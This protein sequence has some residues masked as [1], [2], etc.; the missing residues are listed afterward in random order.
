MVLASEAHHTCS[1]RYRGDILGGAV[2]RGGVFRSARLTR[3][4]E[5]DRLPRFSRF[6]TA[7]VRG[8]GS[9]TSHPGLRSGCIPRRLSFRFRS[10]MDGATA[11]DSAPPRPHS[12]LVQSLPYILKVLK[13]A[14]SLSVGMPNRVY[15]RNS[16]SLPRTFSN[17]CLPSLRPLP[18]AQPPPHAHRCLLFSAWGSA[19]F[20][21]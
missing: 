8:R 10:D 14:C 21:R 9:C 12:A 2:V 6:L 17:T 11:G 15:A 4:R 16:S 13:P 7:I 18:A 19:I 20:H 3:K 5:N 1:F